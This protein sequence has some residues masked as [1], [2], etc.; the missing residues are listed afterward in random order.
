MAQLLIKLAP[1]MLTISSR[2]IC[3][4]R[5]FL[6]PKPQSA[7]ARAEA[8]RKGLG[9]RWR[10]ALNLLTVTV[11]VVE[12][13]AVPGVTVAGEKL[14]VRLYANPGQ[15]K[16]TGDEN[17]FAFTGVIVALSVPCDP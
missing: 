11:S 6:K 2:S 10:L 15:L 17:P 1:T 7:T 5:R 13:E 12:A 16:E 3:M 8:G 14:Q 4:R 9:L